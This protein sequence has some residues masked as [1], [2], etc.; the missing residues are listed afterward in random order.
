ME[1]NEAKDASIHVH[2]K[3]MP[4]PSGVADPAG[5]MELVEGAQ[6]IAK[7]N[8]G[9]FQ[10]VHIWMAVLRMPRAS[11]DILVT[12]NDPSGKYSEVDVTEVVQSL[13]LADWSL[14]HM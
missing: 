12:W 10:S 13:C 14:F 1:D 9:Q 4:L 6:S 8:T 3:A 5:S 2:K 11:T 7:F